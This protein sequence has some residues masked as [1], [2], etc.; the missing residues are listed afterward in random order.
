MT[1]IARCRRTLYSPVNLSALVYKFSVSA[2]FPGRP[3]LG[4]FPRH[5]ECTGHLGSLM[6]I[7]QL[8]PRPSL[9][10]S[11]SRGLIQF[12]IS[13]QVARR[14]QRFHPVPQFGDLATTLQGSTQGY[15]VWNITSARQVETMKPGRRQNGSADG[16]SAWPLLTIQ[17]DGRR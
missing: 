8:R 15:Y 6:A 3:N 7:L 9:P 2:P 10:Y 12:P 13:I 1:V 17:I 11:L 4:A 14:Q 5:Y 16:K